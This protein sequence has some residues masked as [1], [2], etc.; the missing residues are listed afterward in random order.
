MKL[1][2]RNYTKV[3]NGRNVLNH[4]N[5]SLE[6]GKVYGL[7][8]RNGSGKT[9]LFRAM[10]T[11]IFPTEGDV[12]IDSVSI[13]KEN[14]DLRQIGLLLEEPG[15]YPNLS[16]LENLSMLYEIN[17]PKDR[18]HMEDVMKEMGLTDV[19]N[20]KYREYSLGM[21]QRLRIA[22][23]Y[24]EDQKLILLDEPTNGLDEDGVVIFRN[25]IRRLKKQGKLILLASH[26]K[27]DLG[28]LCDVVYHIEAGAITG[29]ISL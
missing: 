21:K 25:L 28:L 11:L 1:E 10:T 16:G 7:Y 2:V 20:R 4:I 29:E 27:E 12:L 15:F 26:S 8:G 19:M 22:Q 3:L 13:L 6:S 23:A 24:M 18:A 5:L 17:H 14:Y 9:M